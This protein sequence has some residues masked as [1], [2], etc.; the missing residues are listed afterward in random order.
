LA[1]GADVHEV[2]ETIEL[3]T[4]DDWW[5]D[6][7]SDFHIDPLGR[8]NSCNRNRTTHYSDAPERVN[9]WARDQFPVFGPSSSDEP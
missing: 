5:H 7:G 9:A 2:D 3:L 4:P 8:A 1:A 6:S